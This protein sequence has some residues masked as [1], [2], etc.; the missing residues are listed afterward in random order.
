MNQ[1][2]EAFQGKSNGENPDPLQ[3]IETFLSF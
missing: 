2:Y 1:I 3:K